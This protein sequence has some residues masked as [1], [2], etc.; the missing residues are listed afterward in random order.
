METNSQQRATLR[1]E[2]AEAIA[3]NQFTLYYQPH[4]ELST[5]N[6]TGCEALIRWNHPTRG[7]LLPG[8]FIP[9]AEQT[10]II[11]SIDA[12]VMRNAFAAAK[13]LSATRPGFRLFFNLSGRQAGDPKLIR[14]FS[15]AARNGVPLGNIGV[16]ITESDA[17][18]D[19]EATRRVCRALRRLGVQIAI[20][21]FGTGYSSLSFLKR[22]PVDVVK[23]DQSFIAGLM[24]DPHDAAITETII[25]IAE[26]FGF[27]SLAEGVERP[28]ELAWLRL[29]CCTYAQGFGISHA[30]PMEAFRSWLTA[31]DA[32]DTPPGAP[33]A[34]GEASSVSVRASAG[35]RRNHKAAITSVPTPPSTTAPTGPS[36]A[37]VTPDSNS[38]SW[39]EVPT[40]R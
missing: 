2:I 38:P 22:L 1:N 24:S 10:G 17:M 30:L 20:D 3:G 28:D 32:G 16:E 31:R 13:E 9:F 7:L 33:Y 23:I 15:D 11:T 35:K 4:I 18:R 26:R 37:A 21:D 8:H 29:W 40:N 14:A 27:A 19:V 6:V 12:W 5:G 34:A 39:F 36:S 25:S